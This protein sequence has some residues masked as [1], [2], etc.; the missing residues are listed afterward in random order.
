M[1]KFITYDL[2]TR[3]TDRAKPYVFCFYRLSKLAGRYN[4]D[5]TP[6]EVEKCRKDTIGFDGDNCDEKVLD[7][8]LKLK[9]EKEKLRL[10][11]SNTI[12]NYTL[13][14]DLVLILGL[15]KTTFLVINT[16]L[17]LLKMVKAL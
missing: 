12:F 14:M 9:G 5:L 17:K 6:C 7:F 3:N 4:R 11:L 13:I 8:C 2:E 15:Y 10:R 1:T 16:L